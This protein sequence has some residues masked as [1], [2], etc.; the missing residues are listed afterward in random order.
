MSGPRGACPHH[1]GER[2]LP[3]LLGAPATRFAKT[4]GNKLMKNY[5]EEYA[6]L[7]QNGEAW[8]QEL[9]AFHNPCA[10][11]PIGFGLLPG[12]THWFEQ[13]GKIQCSSIWQWSVL[14]SVTQTVIER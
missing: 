13:D 1:A 9:E 4:L 14:A 3:W 5:R 7:W 12:A 8:R 10:A 2:H 11:Y 6:A